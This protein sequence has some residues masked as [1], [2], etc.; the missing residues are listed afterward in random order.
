[1]SK[2][3]NILIAFL[4]VAVV[5]LGGAV[6]VLYQ[7]DSAGTETSAEGTNQSG[8]AAAGSEGGGE[9]QGAAEDGGVSSG[10]A[11]LGKELRCSV[12]LGVLKI[13]AGEEFGVLEGNADDCQTA[14]ED[15]Y[16]QYPPIRPTVSQ[17]LCPYR[18]ASVWNAPYSLCPAER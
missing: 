14:L 9:A 18:R 6:A 12:Q 4:L 13:V 3:N 11:E 7:R 16:I 5:I 10:E 15:A 2:I 1:M 17:S 8:S